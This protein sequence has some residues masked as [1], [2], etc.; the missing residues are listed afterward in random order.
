M[1]CATTI[2]KETFTMFFVELK[3]AN[4]KNMYNINFLLQYKL[5]FEQSHTR[6]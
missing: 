4:N 1:E 6:K 3:A 2:Y 5:K